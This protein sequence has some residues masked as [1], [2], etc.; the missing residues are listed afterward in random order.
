M[1]G[2]WLVAASRL[3]LVHSLIV[4]TGQPDLPVWLDFIGLAAAFF[5]LITA[6]SVRTE[7]KKRLDRLDALGERDW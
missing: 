3:R 1:A 5:G 7:I 2:S 6:L 4:K